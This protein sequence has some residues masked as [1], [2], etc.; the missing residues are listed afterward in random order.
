MKLLGPA[1]LRVQRAKELHHE[2]GKPLRVLRSRRTAL[3]AAE[4][5]AA[6]CF[7]AQSSGG[8]LIE[9]M[10][11]EA[12]AHFVEP[13]VALFQGDQKTFEGVRSRTRRLAETMNPGLEAFGLGHAEGVIRA[14]GG[15]DPDLPAGFGDGLMGFEGVGGIVCRAYYFDVHALDQ[16]AR[17]PARPGEEPVGFVP[18]GGGGG[19]VEEGLDAEIAA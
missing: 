11:G 7:S 18:D 16:A 9:A 14:E 12:A 19:F 3:S 15:K 6:A 4:K 2:G 1:F 10:I 5:M 13:V 8:H 17:G